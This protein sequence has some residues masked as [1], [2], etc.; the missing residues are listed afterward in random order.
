MKTTNKH[1]INLCE[2]EGKKFLC[3]NTGIFESMTIHEY[4]EEFGESHKTWGDVNDDNVWD[5]DEITFHYNNDK[6]K[7]L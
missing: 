2:K 6:I 5:A 7:F 4:N 3:R 1:Y